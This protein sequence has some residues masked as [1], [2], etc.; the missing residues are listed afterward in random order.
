M[1]PE[2]EEMEMERLRRIIRNIKD[3]TFAKAWKL[4]QQTGFPTWHRKR[5]QNMNHPVI[6][7]ERAL[8]RR[9]GRLKDE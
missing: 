2:E 8:Y 7:A 1:L 3:G 9:L 5:Q 4:E 6:R